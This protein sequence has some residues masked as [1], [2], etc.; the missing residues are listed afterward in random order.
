MKQLPDYNRLRLFLEIARAGNLTRAADQLNLKKAKLSR[1]LGLLEE[2]IGVQL[3]QR[4]TRQFKLTSPGQRLYDGLMAPFGGIDTLLDQTIQN[5]EDLSGDVRLTCPED[6]GH[7]VINPILAEF[8]KNHPKVTIEVI[9]S[10]ENLDLIKERIDF[11]IRI[12]QLS[13][14]G[15]KRIKLGQLSLGLYS[16]PKYIDSLPK[17]LKWADLKQANHIQFSRGPDKK[18][19]S[20]QKGAKRQSIQIRPLVRVDSYIASLNF[21]IDGLGIGVLPNFMTTNLVQSNQ[22]IP[23]FP[24]WATKPIPIN[25]VF[26]EQV[27]MPLRTQKLKDA[28]VEK[29]R[30]LPN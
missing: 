6:V 29:L 1:D 14:S 17:P 28:L 22:L 4:T 3:F 25:L 26:P 23:L 21:L 9:Y 20:F 15:L 12:G 11:G 7:W 30:Y 27:R 2:D 13:D 10:T 5:Q 16:S 24:E 8:Q 18:S 19:W